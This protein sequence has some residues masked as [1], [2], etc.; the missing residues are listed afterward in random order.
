MEENTRGG[1]KGLAMITTRKL[2]GN[3]KWG[4]NNRKNK[5]EGNENRELKWTLELE[6]GYAATWIGK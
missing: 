3:K 4:R 1:R 6:I 5:C 2:I